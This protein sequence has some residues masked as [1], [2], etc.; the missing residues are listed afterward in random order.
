MAEE[1][2]Y[3]FEEIDRLMEEAESAAPEEGV[4][5]LSAEAVRADP[6]Q[7]L[8]RICPIYRAVRPILQ[9]IL[10]LPFIPEKWKRVIRMFIR[11]MD[12]LCPQK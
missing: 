1:R 6:R 7:I 10:L 11:Y 4:R 12:L 9:G 8:N 5:G 2:E 3:S